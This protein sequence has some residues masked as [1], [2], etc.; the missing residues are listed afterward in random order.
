LTSAT[1]AGT[2]LPLSG[3]TLSGYVSFG[4]PIANKVLTLW[5]GS[6]TDANSNATNFYGFGI[7]ENVLRYQ[8]TA[9]HSHAFFNGS[10]QIVTFGSSNVGIG[11]TSPS[12]ALDVVGQIH[13]SS[14]LVINASTFTDASLNA[15]SNAA[16]AASNEAY[17]LSTT[18]TNDSNAVWPLLVTTSNSLSSAFYEII[19]LQYTALEASNAANYAS[20]IVGS[21]T[22]PWKTCS[23]PVYGVP[24]TLSGTGTY[25]ITQG[26]YDS[27][28]TVNSGTPFPIGVAGFNNNSNSSNC[29][30]EYAGYVANNSGVTIAPGHTITTTTSE[31]AFSFALNSATGSNIPAYNISGATPPMLYLTSYN[32]SAGGITTGVS[33]TFY[34]PS[35]YIG[36]NQN[37][38]FLNMSIQDATTQAYGFVVT[39]ATAFFF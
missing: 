38:I 30:L 39:S 28:S 37:R 24:N 27:H 5:D 14:S 20:N 22:P 2:Y 7:N 15:T 23:W 3:G 33:D 19:A 21:L 32:G 10:N 6:P 25:G 9:G 13:A 18:Y 31:F 29:Y 36:N 35:A 16:Y 26:Y 8:V 11:I 1:A 17:N 4:N 34:F 12:Y